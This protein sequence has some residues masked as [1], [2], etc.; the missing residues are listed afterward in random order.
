MR[1]RT[2]QKH[3]YKESLA[4]LPTKKIQEKIML[5]FSSAMINLKK[6]QDEVN[7]TRASVDEPKENKSCSGPRPQSDWMYYAK[8]VAKPGIDY[9][10]RRFI[11]TDVV[12]TG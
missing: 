4:L 11:G 8:T 12:N 9:V 1:L 6:L 2:Q 3:D 5:Y 7:V 10:K